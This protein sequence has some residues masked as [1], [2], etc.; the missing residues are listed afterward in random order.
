[1]EMFAVGSSL[2]GDASKT[3]VMLLISIGE[4]PLSLPVLL[5][6]SA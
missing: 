4:L 6:L 3:V 2:V 1:M 5:G